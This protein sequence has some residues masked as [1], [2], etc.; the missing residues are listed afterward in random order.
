M[1]NQAAG[2]VLL[3]QVAERVIC[4][5]LEKAGHDNVMIVSG[6]ADTVGPGVDIIYKYAGTTEK[7]KVKP[8]AY[9]G[10]DP[11]KVRDR[12]LP[13]YRSDVGHYAFE[14]VANAATREPGW[15]FQ[16]SADHL[17]YYYVVLGQSEAEVRALV[18]EP[19]EV[20]FSELQVER[21]ELRILPMRA[22][23][24]WFEEHFQEYTPRPVTV[25]ERS[26]WYRLIPRS[27]IHGALGGIKNVGPVFDSVRG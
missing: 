22:T 1:I 9:F 24:D 2:A 11:G 21:D 19:N 10:T 12:S 27:D 6:K 18:A 25:G 16:S 20:F 15:M 8:D 23:Q 5:Y 14:A 13:F 3:Q 26:A 17:Y 7:V 4:R